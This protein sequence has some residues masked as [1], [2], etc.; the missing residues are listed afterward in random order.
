[1]RFYKQYWNCTKFADWLR[2]TPK[3]KAATS[4][5]WGN[6][7]NEARAKHPVRYWIVETG[8][9]KAQNIF[10]WPRDVYDDFVRHMDNRF[11]TRTHALIANPKDIAPGQYADLD[12]R[13]FFCLFNELANYVEVELAWMWAAHHN[14][15]SS[16]PWYRRIIGLE[17]FRSPE[18]GLAYLDHV[19]QTVNDEDSGYR[20]GQPSYGKESDSAKAYKEIRTLY[21]WWTQE[22]PSR[23]DIYEITGWNEVSRLREKHGGDDIFFTKRSDSDLGRFSDS[24]L[25]HIQLLENQYDNE[26]DEMLLRLIKI[27]KCL[28]S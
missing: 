20:P 17:R 13:I 11:V 4:S 7:R 27:R 2:G 8:L 24:S 19:C 6:W 23:P 12:D 28:W 18:D 9:G 16:A 15:M 14:K 26:D 22:R 3:P 21:L 10:N 25:A 1:M 5:G